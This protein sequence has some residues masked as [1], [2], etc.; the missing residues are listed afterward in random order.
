[1]S[2]IYLN[3]NLIP[4]LGATGRRGVLEATGAANSASSSQ[5]SVVFNPAA[6]RGT[7]F[8]LFSVKK[9]NYEEK[10]F[11]LLNFFT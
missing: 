1:M 6:G 4:N 10:V 5:F 3:I 7:S 8:R 11:M 2:N 9:Y